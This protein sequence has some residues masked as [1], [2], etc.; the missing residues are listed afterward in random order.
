MHTAALTLAQ[1]STLDGRAF[2]NIILLIILAV[3]GGMI[4]FSVKRRIFDDNNEQDQSAGTL[5]ESLEHMRKTGQISEEE[6]QQ[7]RRTIIERTKAMLDRDKEPPD[8]K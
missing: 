7:T 2:I 3:I 6:Y 4:I 1:Q 5:M 8:E